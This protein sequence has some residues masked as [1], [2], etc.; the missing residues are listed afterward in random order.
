MEQTES[1]G[2]RYAYF[3]GC[4]ASATGIA[5]TLSSDYIAKKTG[6]ELI[7]IPDWCCCGTSAALVTDN[8]LALALPARSLA[9]AEKTPELANLDV[10]TPC[11]GCF[12]SLKSAQYYVRLGEKQ[13]QHVEDLI[14]M[15]YAATAEVYSFL[16]LM[17]SGQPMEAI[18][19]KITHN[20]RGLKVACYYGCALVRPPAVMQFDDPENPSRMESLISLTGAE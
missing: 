13:R 17:S 8:D 14:Q 6:M 4:S 20:L 18:A 19:D 5:F 11:A 10:A 9:L 2:M 12:A 15:P 1:K 7:E 3:P 16:E